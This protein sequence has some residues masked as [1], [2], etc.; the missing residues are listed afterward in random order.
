M[1]RAATVGILCAQI[2]EGPSW[3]GIGQVSD[4]TLSADSVVSEVERETRVELATLPAQR[5][6]PLLGKHSVGANR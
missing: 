6:S 4:V 5:G 3:S 2:A 1:C